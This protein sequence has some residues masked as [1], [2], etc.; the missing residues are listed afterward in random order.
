MGIQPRD[1]SGREIGDGRY[2]VRHRIGEGGMGHVYRAY[3]HHLK[4]D[5]V[6][7]F[8]IPANPRVDLKDF[9]GI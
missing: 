6:I 3:D 2:T 8:P 5:V 4:S 7:K 1:W 9:L